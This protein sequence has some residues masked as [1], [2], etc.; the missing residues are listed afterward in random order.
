MISCM[1][2]HPALQPVGLNIYSLQNANVLESERWKGKASFT[3]L[4]HFV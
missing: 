2:D 3:H 4:L 1:T